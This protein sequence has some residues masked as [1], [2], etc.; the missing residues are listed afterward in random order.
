MSQLGLRFGLSDT[1]GIGVSCSADGLFV[2]GVPLLERTYSAGGLEQ[3]QPRPASELNRDLGQRYGLPIDFNT[4][5]SGLAEI[6]R[7]HV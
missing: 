6:G 7:A 2:G 1:L 4:R 5:M 3:W